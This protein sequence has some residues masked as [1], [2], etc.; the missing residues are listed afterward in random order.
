MYRTIA[1]SALLGAATFATENNDDNTIPAVALEPAQAQEKK[2]D[3]TDQYRRKKAWEAIIY[4][5]Y[6][7]AMPYDKKLPEA[8]KKVIEQFGFTEKDVNFYTAVRMDWFVDKVGNNIMLLRPNFFLYLTEEEQASHIAIQLERIRAGDNSELDG[9]ENPNKQCAKKFTKAVN[10]ATA[11]ALVGLY[12]KEIMKGLNDAWPHVKHHLF[13]KVG[14]LIAGCAAANFLAWK[15]YDI[16][17]QKHY[18]QHEFV[19]LDTIGADD[20]IAVKEKQVEWGKQNSGWLYPW[21]KL[22]GKLYLGYNAAVK[23]ERY[24]EHV[25][26]KENNKDA[27]LEGW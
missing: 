16:A 27:H 12:H 7:E 23:L 14:M 21:Y 13:S 15:A 9:K 26:A 18:E 24:K 25:K 1:L 11:V 4:D 10:I 6:E 3:N 20:W 19:T 17:E 5:T 2:V 8:Y 22:L